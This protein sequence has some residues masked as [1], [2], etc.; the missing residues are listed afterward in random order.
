M[1]MIIRIIIY[2]VSIEGMLH[3]LSDLIFIKLYEISGIF[4][5]FGG[6]R[7]KLLFNYIRAKAAG[8]S[9]NYEARNFW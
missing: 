3:E 8:S 5:P 7:R 6:T 9:L 2:L 4:S 1:I